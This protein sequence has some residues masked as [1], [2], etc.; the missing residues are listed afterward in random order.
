MKIRLDNV[1]KTLRSGLGAECFSATFIKAINED[2]SQPSAYITSDGRLGYNPSFVEQYVRCPEDLFSLLLHELLHPLWGHFLRSG[3]RLENIAADAVINAAISRLYARPSLRGQLFTQ[4]YEPRG[5]PGLLRPESQLGGEPLERVYGRLYPARSGGYGGDT[6]DDVFPLSTGELIR[7]LRILLDEA[8]VG[9]V[10]LLGT[11]GDPHE[12]SSM[13]QGTGEKDQS[14]NPTNWDRDTL[15]QI[16][17]DLQAALEEPGGWDAGGGSELYQLLQAV[18]QT[19]L[20]FRE[21]ILLRFATTRRLDRLEE[22]RQLELLQR[23]SPLPLHPTRRDLVLLAGGAYPLHFHHHVL[24]ET[25][26]RQGVALYLDVSGSVTTFL[27]QILG[28]LRRL[29]GKL[30]SIYQFSTEVVETTLEA[31]LG[32]EIETT[33]GTD[34]DCIARSLLDAG[35]ERAI[36]ITDGYA[37]LSNSWREELLRRGVR[38]LTVLFG[39]AS[40]CAPLAPLGDVVRLEEVCA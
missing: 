25:T 32:G 5:V 15:E 27:P 40:E 33:Y 30:S 28:I 2:P 24:S 3:G 14:A 22:R 4:L 6:G 8:Q 13:D 35:F 1:R 21:D 10:L 29:R 23:V 18:L 9:D 19:Q 17:T 7:V 37:S 11:H 36:V 12:K 34:F 26:Q 38:L 39:G 16:V 20:G 31:L